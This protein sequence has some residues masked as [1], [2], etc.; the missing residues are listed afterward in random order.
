MNIAQVRTAQGRAA[1]A[2]GTADFEAARPAL[3]TDLYPWGSTEPSAM[4]FT[5]SLRLKINIINIINYNKDNKYVFNMS[6]ICILLLHSKRIIDVAWTCHTCDEPCRRHALLELRWPSRALSLRH[7]PLLNTSLPFV[8]HIY[9]LAFQLDACGR[10]AAFPFL[11]FP[12]PSRPNE[13][14]PAALRP[15]TKISHR[16]L[17]TLRHA[18]HHGGAARKGPQRPET[19]PKTDSPTP[20]PGVTQ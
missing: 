11:S 10:A 18:A 3:S 19:A 2:A 7:Q 20:T 8:A 4:S 15:P 1:V 5:F 14:P 9:I 17:K 6:L 12:F 16:P 13:D